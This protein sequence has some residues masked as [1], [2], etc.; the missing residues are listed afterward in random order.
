MTDVVL[1]EPKPLP[2]WRQRQQAEM[3]AALDNVLETPEG[4]KAAWRDMIWNDHGFVR[5]I[6]PN[7]HRL[8]EKGWRAA[9]PSPRVIAF[10]ASQ[11]V[12]TIISLRGGRQF[13]SLPLQMEACEKAGIT[14]QVQRLFSRALLSREELQEFIAVMKAA[15]HPVV[16]HCKSGAD[17]AGFAS[18]LHMHLIEGQPIELAQSQLSLRYLHLKAAK[19]GVL[20]Y[21]FDAYRARLAKGD[22]SL[23]DWIAQEYDHKALMAAYQNRSQKLGWL[24]ERILRRE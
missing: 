9:Q 16:Y 15:E 8:G 23:E 6:Y 7:I 18:V 4:R 5:A 1:N 13:G 11:G 22:I 21:F 12:K 19:T 3:Q 2:A 20:D 10:F 24:V 14:F 17:R